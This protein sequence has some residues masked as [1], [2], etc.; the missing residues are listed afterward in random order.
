MFVFYSET[1]AGSLKDNKHTQRERE[2]VQSKGYFYFIGPCALLD[3]SLTSSWADSKGGGR[4]TNYCSDEVQLPCTSVNVH[5][6]FTLHTNV[7][8]SKLLH[9]VALYTNT[10]HIHICLYNQVHPNKVQQHTLHPITLH[11]HLQDCIHICTLVQQRLTV[12]FNK[13]H[14]STGKSC[15]CNTCRT[16]KE[17]CALPQ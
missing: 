15:S 9:P 11:V 5:T 8:H 4:P 10:L 3:S 6:H 1:P 7:P 17:D 13:A 12:Q 14:T 2:K 16:C